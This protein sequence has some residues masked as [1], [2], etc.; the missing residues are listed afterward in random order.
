MA[1]KVQHPILLILFNRPA[2]VSRLV[3]AVASVSPQEVFVFCDGPRSSSREDLSK[4]EEVRVVVEA[5]DS[6]CTVRRNFQPINLG[7]Q[8]GPRT[9]IDW[10]FENVDAGIILEDDCIPNDDFFRFCDQMLAEY[11]FDDA[12]GSI[13]GC[14]IVPANLKQHYPEF[15][16]SNYA[17]MWGWA[18]WRGRW[19]R[20]DPSLSSWSSGFCWSALTNIL[21]LWKV[22]MRH[23]LE[24]CVWMSI[25]NETKKKGKASSWW[26]YQWIFTS[27]TNGLNTIVPRENLISNIGYGTDATHTKGYEPLRSALPYERLRSSCDFKA[28]LSVNLEFDRYISRHWFKATSI[29]VIR[30]YI[31]GTWLHQILKALKTRVFSDG[32]EN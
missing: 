2:L 4:I 22:G 5:L 11:R 23:P 21:F 32:R 15:F 10:F 1:Y 17:L 13:C 16:F 18:S 8:F 27:W 3:K 29:G 26:D 20:Y 7:C 28:D 24:F 31:D 30:R 19:K 9:A 14:N 25:F 12:V 6:Q